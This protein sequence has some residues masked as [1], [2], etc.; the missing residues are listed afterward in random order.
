MPPKNGCKAISDESRIAYLFANQDIAGGRPRITSL[1]EGDT[2]A[3][4]NGQENVFCIAIQSQDSGT[5]AKIKSALSQS[6]AFKR[7]CAGPM[8][9]EGASCET[10][11]LVD[12]GR[13]DAGGNIVGDA[14][15]GRSALEAVKKESGESPSGTAPTQGA[16]RSDAEIPDELRAGHDIAA[17]CAK[18]HFNICTIGHVGH[19]KSTLAAAIT[20]RLAQKGFTTA[21]P[22]DEIDN[23]PEERD[24]KIAAKHVEYE[25]EHCRYTHMDCSGDLDYIKD[26]ITGVAQMNCAILV[27]SVADGPM[28]QTR[29][30]ILLARQLNVPDVVVYMNKA[31]LLDDPDLVDLVEL[32][33]RELLSSCAF[34][35]DDIPVIV[36]SALKAVESKG[37][38]DEACKSID[39]LMA[40]VGVYKETLETITPKRPEPIGEAVGV[41]AF[42]G[43]AAGFAAHHL[44]G[45]TMTF[46]IFIV[47][48]ILILSGLKGWG[49]LVGLI[50]FTAVASFVAALLQH[51]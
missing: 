17:D 34:P 38:D 10:E 37:L 44:A 41:G 35:G 42:G 15:S 27:V 5:I 28:P 43:A 21:K 48:Y 49:K 2:A 40:A 11:P 25:T 1:Y 26:M 9:V 4:L 29:D 24:G 20:M 22:C 6:E 19:G 23:A 50:V 46:P 16:S 31:D 12:V 45:G 32:E 7:V 36:G 51:L 33:V 30:H 47:A 8:F 14:R 13:I 3:T 18:P 39:D